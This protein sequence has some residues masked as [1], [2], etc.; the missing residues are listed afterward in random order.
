MAQR[1]GRMTPRDCAWRR[2]RRRALVDARFAVKR[3]RS[4]RVPP[5]NWSPCLSALLDWLAVALD[6][7]AAD[8]GRAA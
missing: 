1:A 2:Q 5:W 4:R 6:E 8:P 7:V 3:G